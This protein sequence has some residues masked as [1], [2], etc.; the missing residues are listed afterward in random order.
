[1]PAICFED[2]NGMP[3]E[4]G[5]LRTIFQ[6]WERREAKRKKIEIENKGLIWRSNPKRGGHRHNLVWVVMWKGFER[7]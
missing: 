6:I 5:S 3:Y 1:M 7:V 4:N 2:E